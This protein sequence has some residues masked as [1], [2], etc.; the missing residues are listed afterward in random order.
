MKLLWD[1]FIGLFIL[2]SV[3]I[4]PYRVGFNITPSPRA[5]SFDMFITALFGLDI[6]V[7][8]NTAYVDIHFEILEY[9]RNKIIQHYLQFWFWIDVLAM[10]PFD[11]LANAALDKIN[12]SAIR[13]IRILRL[14]RLIKLYRLIT[15]DQILEKFHIH[16]ELINLIGLILQ[17]FFI[18]HVIACFWHYIALPDVSEGYANT[19]LLQ[20]QYATGDVGSRYIA[21]LYFTFVTMLTIGYGDIRPTNQLERLYAIFTMLVG[22]LVFGALVQKVALSMNPKSKKQQELMYQMKLFL[23]EMSIPVELRDKA[24]VRNTTTS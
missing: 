9:R 12:I 2:Y 22:G 11:G 3:I 21:S 19:W 1:L 13:I 16:P 10:F 5:A 15:R 4:I 14:V 8:F 6:L 20:F 23:V 24:K 18:A 7:T 17:I